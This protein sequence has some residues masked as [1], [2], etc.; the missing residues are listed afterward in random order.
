MIDELDLV[1]LLTDLPARGGRRGDV[2]TVVHRYGSHAR[3][4]VEFT[5][6]KGDTLAVET[7]TAEQ[8]QKVDLG[9]VILHIN[10]LSTAA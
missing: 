10:D 9:R 6:A 5:N 4:E 1:A 2:G 8:V 7:L 3:Y